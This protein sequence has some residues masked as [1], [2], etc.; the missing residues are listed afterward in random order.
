MGQAVLLLQARPDWPT[1]AGEEL[2]RAVMPGVRAVYDR[3]G[4]HAEM[5]RAFEALAMQIQQILD[6]TAGRRNFRLTGT[7]NNDDFFFRLIAG[8]TRR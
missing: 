8:A 2:E 6:E 1:K 4:Y 7:S 3:H 5:Q